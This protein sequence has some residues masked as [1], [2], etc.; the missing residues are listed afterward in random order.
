MRWIVPCVLLLL[1]LTGCAEERV[2]ALLHPAQLFHKSPEQVRLVL[3]S[4]LSTEKTEPCGYEARYRFAGMDL[5]AQF[6]Q[7]GDGRPDECVHLEVRVP[8]ALA[9]SRMQAAQRVGIDT[10]AYPPMQTH[11][12]FIKWAGVPVE[13]ERLGAD[14]TGEG[15][16][17]TAN[18]YT[19]D[20]DRWHEKVC[21]PEN[22]GKYQPWF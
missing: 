17:L 1:A 10:G 12:D 13:G 2:P 8:S 11:E 16:D 9:G 6:N 22:Y 18:L 5:S 4:P 20:W 3:G 19:A 21:H 15:G 7:Y 14:V